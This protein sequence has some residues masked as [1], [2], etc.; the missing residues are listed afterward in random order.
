MIYKHAASLAVLGLFV[1]LAAGSIPDTPSDS[2]T[3]ADSAAARKGP[4]KTPEQA[5]ADYL[6]RIDRELKGIATFDGTKYRETREGIQ[7][8]AALFGAWGGMIEEARQHTLSEAENARVAELRRKM[9]A[10]QVRELPRMRAAWAKMLG[11][12]MWE[13]DMTV[14]AGGTA[15]RTLRLTAAVFASNRNIKQINDTLWE[16]ASLLR[17]KRLEYRWYKGAEDYQYFTVEG[18]SDGEVSSITAGDAAESDT[19]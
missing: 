15:N 1:V 14:T 5:K 3:G 4:P 2:G 19:R 9:S 18:P 11:E 13:H 12:A 8:G 6:G 7:I 10:V 16:H 17:F